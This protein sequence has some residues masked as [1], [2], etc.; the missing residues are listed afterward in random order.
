[1]LVGVFHKTI[2]DPIETALL[3]DGQAIFLQ[4]NNFGTA[5]NLGL[6]IDL[7][8][9]YRNFGI[10]A[11]YNFT[12]SR[13]TTTKIFRFRD[14]EGNLTSR[15]EMQTRP[16][17]GQSRHISNVSFLYKDQKRRLD[18]QLAMVYTGGR[19]ISVSPY[20]DN[21]IWQRGFT[22]LDLSVEKGFAQNLR[23]FIKINNLLDTPM[24]ADIRLPNTF[25]R[26]QV[27]YLDLTENLMVREDFYR[28]NMLVGIKFNL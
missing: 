22:Q 28:M 7:T 14:T 20:L 23:A 27:P 19:I 12:D 24:R 25:N 10:R 17:Q 11:F 18:V 1:L 13:I 9:Y 21:D 6:E 3:I 15:E 5:T 2:E 8:K 26:E 4:P 16:L